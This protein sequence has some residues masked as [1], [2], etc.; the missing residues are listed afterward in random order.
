MAFRTLL[1]LSGRIIKGTDPGVRLTVASLAS[2][3]MLPHADLTYLFDPCCAHFLICGMCVESF[4]WERSEDPLTHCLLQR[5]GMSQAGLQGI[6]RR[7]SGFLRKPGRS[8]WNGMGTS[9][10][11]CGCRP[12]RGELVAPRGSGC[13]HGR[14]P[15][16]AEIISEMHILLPAKMIQIS[17]REREARGVVQL[18]HQ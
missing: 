13:G 15:R 14:R 17:P 6:C 7:K 1:W 5:P 8:P 2:W 12:K 11:R 16:E 4:T 3:F 18:L 10:T 9:P